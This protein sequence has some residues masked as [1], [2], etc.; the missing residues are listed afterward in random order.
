MSTVTIY[1]SSDDLI[2][3]EGDAK[4]CDEYNAEEGT[5]V[6]IGS[7]GK[8]RVHVSYLDGGVWGIRVSPVEEDAP[9]PVAAI[10]A[11]GYTARAV[12]Q[13]VDMV[14]HEAS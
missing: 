10:S 11:E 4:G 14:I 1:G 12:F 13:D 3:I 6:L 8:A 2:E 9:M 7:E 5:F